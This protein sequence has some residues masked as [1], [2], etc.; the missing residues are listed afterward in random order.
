MKNYTIKLFKKL[1][2]E[3][4]NLLNNEI[5]KKCDAIFKYPLLPWIVGDNYFK[6]KE[7]ILF[8]GKPHRGVPGEKFPSGILDPTKPHLNWLMDCSWPFWSYTKEILIS[9]YGDNDPWSYCSLTNIIKCTNVGGEGNP[10]NDATTYKM[11]ESCIKKLG[12]IF[13]EIEVLKPKHIIFYTYS[14]YPELLIEL[15]FAISINEITDKNYKVKCGKKYLGWWVR[16]V[17]TRWNDEIK[18]LVTGHPERMKKDEFISLIVNWIKEN[19]NP[20]KPLQQTG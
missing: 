20:N 7:K 16:L 19:K 18:I 10:S 6:S 14:L 9:L 3:K 5:C 1:F 15:P 13:E 4:L 17:K 8:V 11:A 12:V 2:E